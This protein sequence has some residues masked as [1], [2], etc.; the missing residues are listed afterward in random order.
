MRKYI[1][2]LVLVCAL[3]VPVV[4]HAA[5]PRSATA[6][7]NVGRWANLKTVV[8]WSFPTA[9]T[10][11]VTS[12]SITV[13]STHGGSHEVRLFHLHL[14]KGTSTPYCGYTTEVHKIG[15]IFDLGFGS[16]THSFYPAETMPRSTVNRAGT[17]VRYVAN[18]DDP[19]IG[20]DITTGFYWTG[21]FLDQ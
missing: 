16:V 21:N 19:D 4:A 6:Y 1:A 14:N 8:Y 13:S 17:Q 15:S 20:C 18:N 2:V 9:T 7:S 10:L 11:K 5:L 12:A 3:A